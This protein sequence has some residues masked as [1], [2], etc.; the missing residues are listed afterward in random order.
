MRAAAAIGIQL[1][2]TNVA[3]AQTRLA[4]AIDCEF[5]QLRRERDMMLELIQ[6]DNNLG[7]LEFWAEKYAVQLPAASFREM[8]NE[9]FRVILN[10]T[11]KEQ[12]KA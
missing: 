9:A 8:R 10:Q 5:A 4:I 3:I 7:M 12:A 11:G 1:S 6:A 2:A